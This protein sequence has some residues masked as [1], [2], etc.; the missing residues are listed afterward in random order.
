MFPASET[1]H[2]AGMAIT[3]DLIEG[4]FSAYQ[5]LNVVAAEVARQLRS[6]DPD[7][8]RYVIATPETGNR[9]LMYKTFDQHL[10]MLDLEYAN[11]SSA[12]SAAES[13]KELAAAALLP[14]LPGMITG[15]L[16]AIGDILEFFRTDVKIDAKAVAIP[17]DAL[18]AAM[19]RS[20]PG[21]ALYH[22]GLYTPGALRADS[23]GVWARLRELRRKV[24]V[25]EEKVAAFDAKDDAGKAADPLRNRI[26]QLKAANT[27]VR[28]LFTDMYT[29][30]NGS[31]PAL[32]LMRTSGLFGIVNDPN[33]RLLHLS[34]AESGGS[35]KQTDSF[36]KGHRAAHNGGTLV[37][38]FSL[39]NSGRTRVAGSVGAV[40]G[41]RKLET[42][43][44]GELLTTGFTPAGNNSGA[45]PASGNE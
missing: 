3:G 15:T 44:N 42:S 19:Q 6:A 28:A 37:R 8:A 17:D 27:A 18:A 31:S 33:T 36:F 24:G 29:T 39:D 34:V 21:V 43:N 2:T 12:L 38:F 26:P 45:Q 30:A 20:L 25:F 5:S 7:A 22:P 41:Y 11:L 10:E 40:H 16:G 32:E 14:A 1:K 23:E 13:N 35:I 4:K 9:I